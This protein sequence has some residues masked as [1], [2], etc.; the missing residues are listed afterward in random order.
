M[1]KVSYVVGS[2]YKPLPE[3]LAAQAEGAIVHHY[4]HSACDLC[5]KGWKLVTAGG[6]HVLVAV[7]A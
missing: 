1:E 6:G 3:A 5:V 7:A 4:W 2:G